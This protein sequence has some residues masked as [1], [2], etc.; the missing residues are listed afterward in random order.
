MSSMQS[1]RGEGRVGFI[2][3]LVAFIAAAFVVVKIVPVR[4]DGYNFRDT[5]RQEARFAAIHRD[6]EEV[7]KRIMDQAEVLEVPLEPKNLTIRR[8]VADVIITASYD[9]TIDLKFTTYTYRFRG[10]EK[11]PLF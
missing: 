5:L 3:T 10:Q 9:Q 8:T 7:R 1:Q 2:I 4:V 6:D 11:A